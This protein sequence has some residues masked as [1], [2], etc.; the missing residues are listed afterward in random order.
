M[1]AGKKFGKF[2]ASVLALDISGWT[3][4]TE[5]LSKYGNKGIEFLSRILYD[6]FDPCINMIYSFGG[7][8]PIF[9]GDGFLVILSHDF[10][11]IYLIEEEIHKISKKMHNIK[12]EY[13]I[14]NI[15]IKSNI[16]FGPINWYIVDY[17]DRKLLYFSGKT[18]KRLWENLSESIHDKVL[19]YKNNELSNKEKNIIEINLNDHQ[20]NKYLSG[21]S[22][23]KIMKEKI[24][25]EFREVICIF[26]SIKDKKKE[27]LKGIIRNSIKYCLHYGGYFDSLI[28]SDKGY[29]ILL[30]FGIPKTYEDNLERALSCIISIMQFRRNY[31]RAGITEGKHYA[32]TIGNEKRW[33]YS[34]IG[35]EV[36]LSSRIA[37]NAKWG[38]I[39]VSGKIYE[40]AVKDF[41][42]KKIGTFLFKGKEN[43][44]PIY[45]ILGK[46][47]SADKNINDTF[48]GRKTIINK[49]DNYF[50]SLFKIKKIDI[51]FI[52]GSIGSGKTALIQWL[53]RSYKNHINFFLLKCERF[54]QK[55]LHPFCL[56]LANYFAKN[57]S[58]TNKDNILSFDKRFNELKMKAKGTNYYRELKFS[59]KYIAYMIGLQ[60][61]KEEI[62][63]PESFRTNIERSLIIFFM[64]LCIKEKKPSI[65]IF[66]DYHLID[67]ES[68]QIVLKLAESLK[69]I[70]SM[71]ICSKTSLKAY[72]PDSN[73]PK[74]LKIK[75]LFL[76]NLLKKETEELITHYLG[77]KPSK[78]LIKEILKKT[79]PNPLF[80]KE[81]CIFIKEHHCIDTILNCQN[82]SNDLYTI[83]S[84]IYHIMLSKID[85]MN[86]PLKELI[87]IASI[88]GGSFS[89]YIVELM[90][91][92]IKNS[93]NLKE[94]FSLLNKS[95][96]MQNVL[97][98]THLNIWN[99]TDNIYYNFSNNLMT[100]VSYNTQLPTIIKNLHEIAASSIIK[101]SN[102]NKAYYEEIAYHFEKAGNK[103]SSD[104]Y[105][106]EAAE[107]Y[108]EKFMNN[109]AIRVYKKLI[110]NMEDKKSFLNIR[111]KYAE[112]LQLLGNYENAECLYR[113]NIEISRNA[114]EKEVLAENLISLGYLLMHKG[115]I[116]EPM[117]LFESAKIIADRLNNKILLA[118]IMGGI[119]IYYFHKLE[120]K[121]A[122]PYLNKQKIIAKKNNDFRSYG[123]SIANIAN[124]LFFLGHYKKALEYEYE[125]IEISKKLNDR[126]RMC[127]VY[128]N[129]GLTYYNMSDY[130][131]SLHY[132]DLQLNICSEIEDKQGYAITISNIGHIHFA[133]G[134]LDKAYHCYKVA[135]RI[136]KDIGD[137]MGYAKTYGHFGLVFQKKKIF[138]KALRYFSAQ[139]KLCRE[140][141]DIRG[142]ALAKGY[143]G[144]IY[145]E[146][147]QFKKAS[148]CFNFQK[149]VFLNIGD[150]KG[151]GYAL[152]SIGIIMIETQNYSEGKK[153]IEESLK[154]LKEIGAKGYY[155]FFLM[156]KAFLYFYQNEISLAKTINKEVLKV[157]ESIKLN[158]IVIE[159]KIFTCILLFLHQKNKALENLQKLLAENPDYNLSSQIKQILDEMH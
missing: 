38:S 149:K 5:T 94:Y 132:Y 121:K 39:W 17:N 58:I 76:K 43:E 109:D 49:I 28:Y 82:I 57:N 144:N 136:S 102:H 157:A 100:E 50:M 112:V 74:Q 101:F 81:I 91:N 30:V 52:S 63:N 150:K 19:K 54:M 83:P 145:I 26:I 120:Y 95:N 14:F 62:Y 3:V 106:Q 73:P 22:L 140:L 24:K 18:I 103:N 6:F 25:N 98:G 86:E 71:I 115:D 96:L 9:S 56:F 55:P 151:L 92:D 137:K 154:I 138:D 29:T 131:K 134:E 78:I 148:E 23:E 85:Q 67:A 51:L 42:L 142:I 133:R 111:S 8:I 104:I 45:E 46:K 156:Q 36:N 61:I 34:I 33:I 90:L 7:F 147:K 44:L 116:R 1:F 40:R 12:T 99:T 69:L 89:I 35:N 107:Y 135:R 80:L 41:S 20:I 11:N 21:I 159:S 4:M 10:M 59:K 31:L 15:T 48:I 128:G 119:G 113:E 126:R 72:N 105:Y 84:N 75:E 32:G 125:Y 152:G 77:Y 97:F 13:G 155:A 64:F 47:I 16:E 27:I 129:I 158:E 65:L 118:R 79:E 110:C 66:Q 68:E 88:F 60:N 127:I 123:A 37:M 130:E 70:N 146:R 139:I 108:K 117:E 143:I 93:T 53:I 153:F 141:D 114:N 122:L 124:I 2:T 87:I